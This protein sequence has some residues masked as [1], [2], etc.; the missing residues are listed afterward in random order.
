MRHATCPRILKLKQINHGLRKISDIILIKT[1]IY[2]RFLL[3]GFKVQRGSFPTRLLAQEVT[4]EAAP[5]ARH[6]GIVF[7]SALYFK[8][9]IYILYRALATII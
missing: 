2:D 7:D 9:S 4:V 1:L 3:A 5:L 8:S 6:L